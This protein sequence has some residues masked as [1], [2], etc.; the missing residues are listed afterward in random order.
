MKRTVKTQKALVV[1]EVAKRHEVSVQYVYGCI[2]GTHK[3]G[4]S[5]QIN[6]DYNRLMTAIT[7][8]F[9]NQRMGQ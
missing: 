2:N 8:V 1:K 6:R 4:I 9:E 5:E 3:K 7:K